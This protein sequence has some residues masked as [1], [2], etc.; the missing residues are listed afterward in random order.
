MSRLNH[1]FLAVL[2]LFSILTMSPMQIESKFPSRSIASEVIAAHPKYEAR[3]AKI[4]RTKIEIDKDL[5]LTCFS[6]RGECLP[7]KTFKRKKRL[8]S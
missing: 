7:H 1:H 5:D 4:D 2:P 8:Q 3:A 6:E